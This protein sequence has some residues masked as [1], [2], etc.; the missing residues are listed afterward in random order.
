MFEVDWSNPNR[1][2]VGDRRAR[3]KKE[4]AKE[5]DGDELEGEGG[6]GSSRASESLRSSMSSVEKQFGFFGAKQRNNKNG[7]RN[8]PK[9]KSLA[10]SSLRAPTIDEL[11]QTEQAPSAA[12]SLD[13][14]QAQGQAQGEGVPSSFPLDLPSADPSPSECFFSISFLSPLS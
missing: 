2:L 10:G 6:G 8:K 5:R 11:P 13:G 3:K 12:P 9:S 1:E 14:R 7:S 4:R